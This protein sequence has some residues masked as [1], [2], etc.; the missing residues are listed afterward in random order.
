MS[1]SLSCRFSLQRTALLAT[2]MCVAPAVTALGQDYPSGAVRIVVPWS[3]G[4]A[5]DTAARVATDGLNRALG[6]RVYI[7]NRPG[8]SGTTGTAGVLQSKADG[9]TLVIGAGPNMVLVP[10]VKNVN[11]DAERDLVPLGM[12]WDSPH[13][14]VVGGGSPITTLPALIAKAKANPGQI[15][16]GAGGGVGS[17]THMANILLQRETDTKMI[18][19]P[20]T[21]TAGALTDVIGGRVDSMFGDAALIAPQLEA[22][23]NSIRALAITSAKRSF[24]LPNVPTMG[25]LGYPKIRS[26]NWY[27]LLVSAKTPPAI[28][29][30][31]RAAVLAMQNDPAYIVVLAKNGIEIQTKGAEPFEV[32]VREQSLLLG[33]IIKA[34]GVTF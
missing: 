24:L 1:A 12:I 26:G 10:M 30:K 11:Y 32:F 23:S 25:E 14:L 5:S 4:G 22:T 3:A 6:T 2:L 16:I 31:L 17:M 9:Y 20:Y 33:P 7:E 28:I 13:V 27:G 15:T 29:A 34:S 8:G 21:A 19:V 18:N